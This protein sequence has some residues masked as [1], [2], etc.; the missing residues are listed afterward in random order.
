L[1]SDAGA[2]AR[3]TLVTLQQHLELFD[4]QPL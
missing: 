1:P 2:L 3:S 4:K